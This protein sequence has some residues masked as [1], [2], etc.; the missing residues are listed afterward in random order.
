M[1]TLVP[2]PLDD[3]SPLETVALELLR[4][5][6][7]NLDKNI[8]LIEEPKEGRRRWIHFGLPREAIDSFVLFN[9]QTQKTETPHIIEKLKQG[10]H[11]YLMSDS[12]LP[13]VCDPGSQLVDA[14]HNA[15][16]RVT[17]TPFPNS[18]MLALALSGFDASQFVFEGFLP[19]ESDARQRELTRILA[20]PRVSIVMDTPY[21]LKS[22]LED[23]ATL[24]TSRRLFVALDLNQKTEELHRGTIKQ[25]IEKIADFKREFVLVV[26]LT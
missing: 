20:L 18:M 15:G 8:F 4:H 9:E 26:G 24:K 12:G 21:R 19:R 11:V 16:I 25:I 3:D 5:A 14:C 13:C 1:L 22:L 23:I 7:Q 17:S 6:S 10:H 2:T